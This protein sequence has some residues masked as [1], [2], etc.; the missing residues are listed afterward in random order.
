MLRVPP[1]F[2]I[3]VPPFDI[4]KVH[5]ANYLSSA[6][7]YTR[8]ICLPNS[9]G[10]NVDL[11]LYSTSADRSESSLSL[12]CLFFSAQVKHLLPLASDPAPPR[13]A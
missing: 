2:L 4:F 1:L 11:D 9:P 5:I 10:I 8:D 6:A 3:T 13:T 12:A 7:Y